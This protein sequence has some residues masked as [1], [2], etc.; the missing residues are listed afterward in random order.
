MSRPSV[1]PRAI[2][3]VVFAVGLGVFAIR[4]R[5]A[6][7]YALPTGGHLFGGVACL[8]LGAALVAREWPRVVSGLLIGLTAFALFPALFAIAAES[9]EVVVLHATDRDGQPAALRLWI[10][11]REDGAWLGMARSKAVAHGLDGEPHRLLRDGDEICVVPRVVDDRA[12]ARAVHAHKI[13]KYRVAQVTSRIGLYPSE[14]PDTSVAVRADA[15]A[16]ENP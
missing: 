8:G 11:D 15:C 3:C 14:A 5:H 6:G 9:E 10:V 13:E 7:P 12:V 16:S 2:G 1:L 4:L